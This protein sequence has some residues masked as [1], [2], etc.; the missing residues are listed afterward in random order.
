MHRELE[1]LTHGGG[2]YPMR[3]HLHSPLVFVVLLAAM[4]AP[5]VFRDGNSGKSCI[6]GP[7]AMVRPRYVH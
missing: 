3:M 2:S 6:A 7:A 5:P 4:T 1:I